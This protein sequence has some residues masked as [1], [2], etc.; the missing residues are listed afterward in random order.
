MLN[1]F[2]NAQENVGALA[3]VYYAPVADIISIPPALGSVIDE[4]IVFDTDK[5]FYE[6]EKTWNTSGFSEKSKDNDAGELFEVSA[7][8][9]FA[10]DSDV[11][12]DGFNK[13]VNGKYIVLVQDNNDRKYLLGTLDN[14]VSVRFNYDTKDT[15]QSRKGYSVVFSYTV[16]AEERP[17]FYQSTFPV[18]GG[19]TGPTTGGDL[20]DA[21]AAIAELQSKV[22]F[23]DGSNHATNNISWDGNGITDLASINDIDDVIA[24][25][26]YA[27]ILKD[28]DGT[29][30]IG[31]G[32]GYIDIA[33]STHKILSLS[34]E[35]LTIP[36]LQKFQDVD[37]YFAYMGDIDA[38]YDYIDALP[39]SGISLTD[40][41]ALG[42]IEYDNTTGVFYMH[43][44]DSGHDGYLTSSYFDIFN[45]KQDAIGY[46]PVDVA[47]DVMLGYLSLWA[48]PT[49]SMHAA[50]KNYVDSF[51]NGITWK[52][53]VKAATTANITLSGTQT[54]D[55]V[56][57]VA[58]NRCLVKNQTSAIENGIYIVSAGAWVRAEDA[59]SS[60]E[61][62]TATCLVRLGTLN[63]DTQWT[64]TNTNEPIIGTDNIT[65]G[66]IAT[67]GAVYT[68]GTGLNLSANVFSLDIS[69]T[70]GLYASLS[71]SYSNPSWIT[72]LAWSKVSGTP[73]TL[74]GYGITNAWNIAGNSGSGYKV[75]TTSA[76]SFELIYNSTSQASIGSYGTLFNKKVAGNYT[77]VASTT[78]AM[79]AGATTNTSNVITVASTTGLQIGDGVS[80]TGI[81]ANAYVVGQIT[82]TTFRISTNATATNTGLTITVQ[83]SLSAYKFQN[84]GLSQAN[85]YNSAFVIQNNSPALN[86]ASLTIV[87]NALNDVGTSNPSIRIFHQGSS[88]GNT[89]YNVLSVYDGYFGAESFQLGV[90]NNGQIKFSSANGASSASFYVQ[91]GG[92]FLYVNDVISTTTIKMG[93]LGSSNATFVGLQTTGGQFNPSTGGNT[94]DLI[95]VNNVINQT[96]SATGAIT[97][98]N[99]IP[100]VTSV[101]GTL[102]AINSTLASA[103]NIAFITAGTARWQTQGTF[104]HKNASA[105]TGQTDNFQLY[106][107]DIVAGN[108]AP[109]FKTENG[110]IVKIY[111]I[112]GWGTPSGTLDRTTYTIYPWITIS[113]SYNQGEVQYLSDHVTMLS[114]R[115]GA[116]I[117]DLKTGHGLIKS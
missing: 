16:P 69:Y 46:T 104:F 95:K 106:A 20:A 99:V 112:A 94:Y 75:G 76:D 15:F 45:G 61:I 14:P 48:D 59:N 60:A 10:G 64:C 1:L 89:F 35:A 63:Q 8:L 110:D 73:T 78:F 70:N 51:L 25:D 67:G 81:P 83:P 84:T 19:T 38:V 21:L 58:N 111:S 11:I 116:L 12:R 115:L 117:T 27:R 74:S 29:T 107:S 41:S 98:F 108:S 2:D 5:A 100:T 66:Q 92:G 85:S 23:K 88:T 40:L 113:A 43:V 77:H 114:M 28:R 55:G 44:A 105:E 80:G 82:A 33:S 42:P 103:S 34:T 47:G 36:R 52:Q 90:T 54:V 109:Y 65:F 32:G 62:V 18:D 22:L 53:E 93:V 79:S 50:T 6:I 96:G 7:S 26:V 3:R 4:A 102:T 17:P 87:N 91:S 101:T 86:N 30:R 68:N 72:S 57:L 37:D 49:S 71:G 13:L 56:A 97:F 39:P 24:F 31:F 9:F